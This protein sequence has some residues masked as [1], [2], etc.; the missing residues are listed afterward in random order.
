MNSG[1]SLI[2]SDRAY[3]LYHHMRC[4]CGKYLAET[5]RDSHNLF[6]LGVSED[7]IC[8]GTCTE[9]NDDETLYT[10]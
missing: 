6:R 5:N 4:V 1:N 10:S 8:N 2:S 3:D 9:E 7:E